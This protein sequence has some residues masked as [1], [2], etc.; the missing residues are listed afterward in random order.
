MTSKLS[1]I[2]EGVRFSD[3]VKYRRNYL[4][5]CTEKGRGIW[6]EEMASRKRLYTSIMMKSREPILTDIPRKFHSMESAI[7]N[8]LALHEEINFIPD[9]PRAPR[10]KKGSCYPIIMRVSQPDFSEPPPSYAEVIFDKGIWPFLS[11]L[12]VFASLW[13]NIIYRHEILVE[14]AAEESPD[15]EVTY[16]NESLPQLLDEPP[17]PLP[18]VPTEVRTALESPVVAV[19]HAEVEAVPV[20]PPS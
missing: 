11:L 20:P 4:S 10:K 18:P 5:D 1:T 3:D 8:A 6:M 15:A 2:Y 16:T 9:C 14:S 17:S 7:Q 19:A 12:I 13:S